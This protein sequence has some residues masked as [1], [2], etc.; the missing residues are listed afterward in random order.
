MVWN[1]FDTGTGT[2]LKGNE[3]YCLNEDKTGK[4]DGSEMFPVC[5]I[6]MHF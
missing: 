4:I 6:V 2:G 5:C 1:R 3:E